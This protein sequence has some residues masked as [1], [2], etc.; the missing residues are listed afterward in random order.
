MTFQQ[1]LESTGIPCVYGRFRKGEQPIAPPY[2]AYTGNGQ[3]NFEA[4]NAYYYSENSYQVEYYFTKKD[5]TKE[6]AIERVLLENGYLYDKSEDT[7]I[8]D[9]GVYLIYYYI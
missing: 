5:E 3:N 7:F 9:E 6:A 4:D 1:V 2:I 8:E